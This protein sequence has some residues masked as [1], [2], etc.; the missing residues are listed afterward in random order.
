MKLRTMALAGAGSVLVAGVAVAATGELKTMQVD[1]HDGTV[2]KIEYVGD[3]APKGVLVPVAQDAAAMD[4]FA[5]L[6]RIALQMQQQ[7]QM[8][9]QQMAALQQQAASGAGQV[10]QAPG[11]VV[12][13]S[14]MPAGSSYQYTVVSTSDGKGGSCTQTIEWKSDGSTNQPQVT[15]ASSGDCDSV[16]PNTTPVPASVPQAQ[17]AKPFDP[18]TI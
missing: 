10:A 7:H 2:A 5:E 13:T 15:R 14:K 12:V 8:M 4:P 6:D 11:Q 1:L 3:V 18:R 16:K 9:M 17:P